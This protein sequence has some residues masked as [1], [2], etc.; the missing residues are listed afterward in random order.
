[1]YMKKQA[2]S[3]FGVLV[4]LLAGGSVY[5]QTVHV[6]VTVPFD[7]MVNN[8]TMPAGQYEL[9]SAGGANNS[10]M[11]GIRRAG[12]PIEIY[13]NTSNVQSSRLA[14]AT[15]LVFQEYGNTYFLS[16]LWT[17]GTSAGREFPIT[18]AEIRE[19]KNGAGHQITLAAK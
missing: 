4:M 1:M 3:L 9:L 14:G 6:Q 5:A 7:F 11:L 16:Q 15:K 8:K 13:I 10:N 17:A 18:G 2:L 12:G 19:A